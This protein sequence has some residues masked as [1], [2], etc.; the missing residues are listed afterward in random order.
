MDS[1]I[2]RFLD[3]KGQSRYSQT[4]VKAWI[5]P[6]TSVQQRAG[7]DD[8]HRLDH[9]AAV[10]ASRVGEQA[11]RPQLSPNGVSKIGD[12]KFQIE[13]GCLAFHKFLRR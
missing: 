10:D 11:A 1:T 2:P 9:Y 3:G 4:A 13:R 7:R 8:P 5:R 6:C 12:F